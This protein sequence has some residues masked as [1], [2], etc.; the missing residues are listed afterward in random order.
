MMFN[1]AWKDKSI[2]EKAKGCFFIQ[3]VMYKDELGEDRYD[4]SVD[5]LWKDIW[6][7]VYEL[8]ILC[9]MNGNKKWVSL[10]KT[11]DIGNPKMYN[12]L[13]KEEFNK[14]FKKI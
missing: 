12:G 14:I 6:M 2:S 9:D 1:C 13:S 11:K 5:S 4:V 8:S 7:P 3:A 10:G